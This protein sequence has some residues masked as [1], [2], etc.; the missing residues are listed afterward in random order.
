MGSCRRN[1]YLLLNPVNKLIIN[2]VLE[3][4]DIQ[5]VDDDDN[6]P[7]LGDR[8]NQIKI[9]VIQMQNLKIAR[10]ELE[11]CRAIVDD[12]SARTMSKRIIFESD[13]G[14]YTAFLEQN[15]QTQQNL[16][17]VRD[18]INVLDH[19]RRYVTSNADIFSSPIDEI[20]D[21]CP[22]DFT[23]VFPQSISRS[24]KKIRS[25]DSSSR[26]IYSA[27]KYDAK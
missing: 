1:L 3:A 26:K 9:L 21:S 6:Q 15:V 17:E 7:S 12:M 25:R 4:K 23:L 18:L 24:F 11:E 16:T 13:W 8:V 22:V 5:N 2:N 19:E 10:N 20:S 14:K 27:V